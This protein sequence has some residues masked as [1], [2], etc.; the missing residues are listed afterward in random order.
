MSTSSK[1]NM[2]QDIGELRYKALGDNL[3]L[4]LLDSH[5]ITAP[6]S[7]KFELETE[8]AEIIKQLQATL[9][10]ACPRAKPCTGRPA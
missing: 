10:G 8:G 7:T 4:R 5:E 1:E 3:F 9:Y 2:A 6:W